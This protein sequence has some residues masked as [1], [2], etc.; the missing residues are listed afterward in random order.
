[1]S[2][3]RS[4][5]GHLR[6]PATP[7]GN[8]AETRCGVTRGL[9]LGGLYLH[10]DERLLPV[11]RA[12]GKW[13]DKGAGVHRLHLDNLVI[14]QQLDIVD[15]AQH[16]GAGV[17]VR[18]RAKLHRRELH[19]HLLQRLEHR[20]LLGRAGAHHLHLL[21]LGQDA[22]VHQVARRK[23]HPVLILG[24]HD[25][26]DLLPV[27]PLQR[28]VCELDQQRQVELELLQGQMGENTYAPSIQLSVSLMKS[29]R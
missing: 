29:C 9:W 4:R 11:L 27:A 20:V 6:G 13:L 26:K 15:A 25:G 3:G 12:L 5:I 7:G 22:V 10:G 23:L 1:M 18:H 17:L 16:K 19:L 14:Q 28:R 21:H 24:A 2:C 8:T